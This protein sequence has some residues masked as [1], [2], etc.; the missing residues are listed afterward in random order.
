MRSPD[1]DDFIWGGNQSLEDEVVT[2]VKNYISVGKEGMEAFKYLVIELEHK[3]GQ[4]RM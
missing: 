1:V 4:M 2:S 3:N